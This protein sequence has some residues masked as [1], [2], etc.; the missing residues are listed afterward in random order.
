MQSLADEFKLQFFE[1]SAKN[2]I[3]V[4]ECFQSIA[5][6]C[7]VRL[8]D[9]GTDAGQGGGTG[10]TLRVGAGSQ[11]KQQKSGCC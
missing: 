7:M 11:R 10:P 8:R 4:D 3:N 5:R 9:S 2:N 6:D 1:T